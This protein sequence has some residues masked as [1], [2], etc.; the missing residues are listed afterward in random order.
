[1]LDATGAASEAFSNIS[2]SCVSPFPRCMRKVARSVSKFSTWRVRPFF[3]LSSMAYLSEKARTRLYMQ[4][5]YQIGV[6]F[7][8]AYYSGSYIIIAKNRGCFDLIKVG[9]YAPPVGA[10]DTICPLSPLSPLC[11]LS[12]FCCACP[13]AVGLG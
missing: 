11:R 4:I 9:G 7:N 8:F 13:I 12:R 1:M 3:V 10:N 2:L 5:L 6:L